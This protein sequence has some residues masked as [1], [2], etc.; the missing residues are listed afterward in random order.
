MNLN[1]TEGGENLSGGQRQRVAF[2]RS[3]Y[4]N[5]DVMFLDEITSALD[6]ESEIELLN[7]LTLMK[8]DRTIIIISHSKNI[9]E[10]CDDVYE[11]KHGTIFK[12]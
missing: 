3:I 6:I 12:L 9:L 2:A 8:G 4:H 1:I 10:V 7:Q 11:V 5:R